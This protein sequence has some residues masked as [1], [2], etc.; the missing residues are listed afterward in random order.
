M[1]IDELKEWRRILLFRYAYQ[2]KHKNYSKAGAY[3]R[4]I[5][6]IG[7]ELNKRLDTTQ[8]SS[9]LMDRQFKGSGC[10]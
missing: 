4:E 2:D 7:E 5:Q 6:A 9:A 3:T 1:T 10:P 8:V